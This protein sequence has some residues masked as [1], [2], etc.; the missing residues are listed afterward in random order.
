M[1]RAINT[2]APDPMVVTIQ[3]RKLVLGIKYL[4]EEANY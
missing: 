3:E 1:L 4:E 2:G